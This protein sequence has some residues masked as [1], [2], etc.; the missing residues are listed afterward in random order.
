MLAASRMSGVWMPGR[1]QIRDVILGAAEGATGSVEALG[2]AGSPALIEDFD[3]E[4]AMSLADGG[5]PS[6]NA[7]VRFSIVVRQRPDVRRSVA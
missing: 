1:D 7:V 2:A 4:V 6:L 5:V 3:V